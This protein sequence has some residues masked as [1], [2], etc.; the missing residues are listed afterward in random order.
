MAVVAGDFVAGRV[1]HGLALGA[2]GPGGRDGAERRAAIV[3]AVAGPA[4]AR[5]ALGRVLSAES[6]NRW[7]RLQWLGI[8]MVPA[9]AYHFSLAVLATT[10]YRV[11]RRRWISYAFYILSIVSAIDAVAG[12]AIVG[13]VRYTP[14]LSYLEGGPLFWLFA[15][16]FALAIGLALGN[17]WK[18]RQRCLTEST[19]TRILEAGT[20]TVDLPRSPAL[21]MRVK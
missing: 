11:H 21:R 2:V 4:L 18:A 13:E 8:T 19:R 16:Y 20:M 17:I 14:P 12:S 10:N 15:A 3:V 7:L 1:A 6:A 5:I 9:A